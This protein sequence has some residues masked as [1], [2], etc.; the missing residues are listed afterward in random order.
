MLRRRWVFVAVIVSVFALATVSIVLLLF[1]DG[2]A[3]DPVVATINGEPVTFDEMSMVMGKF[4]VQAATFFINGYSMEFN[5]G[6]WGTE[7][8][9]CTPLEYLKGLALDYIAEMKVQQQFLR[10]NGE[11]GD[12]SYKTFLSSYEAENK[13][14][15]AVASQGGVLYG[16]E[17]FDEITYYEYLFVNQVQSLLDNMGDQL[18]PVTYEEIVEFYESNFANIDEHVGA[19]SAGGTGGAAGEE[20][21]GGTGSAE[22]TGGSG[23][24]GSVGSANIGQYS[25]LAGREGAIMAEIQMR[26]YEAYAEQLRE[27]A[28]IV[29][30]NEEFD[31][32]TTL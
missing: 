6:F 25:G 15:K 10:E 31:K 1:A 16:V 5:E 17:Q 8:D 9:G 23:G 3:V 11:I 2:T 26:K 28:E 14:R 30:I 32:L 4:R 19:A 24:S 29:I 22:G 12:F 27:E 21:T 20:G 7:V 18:F 13:R